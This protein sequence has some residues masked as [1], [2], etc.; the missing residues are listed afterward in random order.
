MLVYLLFVLGFIFL[1]KGAQ[2]FVDGASSLARHFSVSE[3]TIGLTIVA[4]GT[5][6]PELVV[7]VL[8]N[9]QGV[10]SIGLG[11]TIGSTLGNILLIA[12]VVTIIRPLRVNPSL[13][14][15]QL[16]LCVVACLLLAATANNFFIPSANHTSIGWI[17]GI[18]L[19][20]IFAS[21]IYMTIGI[22]HKHTKKE[23]NIAPQKISL[24]K[25]LAQTGIGIV[26]L[27]IG[28]HWIVGGALEISD[29]LNISETFV[30]LIIVSVGTLMPELVT[31]IIASIKHHSD[32]ALGNIFGSVIF[33]L[34]FIIGISAIIK[35]I[36]YT[37]SFNINL[38]ILV[39][40]ILLLTYFLYTGKKQRYL[41]R[42]EGITLLCGYLIY[43]AAAALQ[44]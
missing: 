17:D 43:I 39:G 23:K 18:L 9:W 6:M 14:R 21:F 25:T 29:L 19:V 10:S 3:L 42:W 1:V 12:G 44:G 24:V 38:A 31:S 36:A 30:G 26:A 32:L 22:A 16:P 15:F 11:S 7:M 33:N 40:A 34:G 2:V 4:F 20:S 27:T 37:A 41:E 13:E 5:S 8:S 28:G 35:P